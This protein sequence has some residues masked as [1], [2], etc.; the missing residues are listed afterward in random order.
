M[1][2][3]IIVDFLHAICSLSFALL[4]LSVA[5]TVIHAIKLFSF[6]AICIV[7]QYMNNFFGELVI[8]KQLSISRAVYSLPWEEYPRKIK[9]SVLF[10]ILRTERPIVINGFKMYLLCYKTFVEF[11]KAIISYYTV[12]RSVH[13]EK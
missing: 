3:M 11:L 9:S 1:E 2:S 7:H 13:L 5:Y 12:L 10:M 6:I 4:E 8:Q